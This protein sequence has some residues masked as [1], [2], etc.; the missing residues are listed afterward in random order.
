MRGR[1]PDIFFDFDGGVYSPKF[2][3]GKAVCDKVPTAG[4][5]GVLVFGRRGLPQFL[6]QYVFA[7]CGATFAVDVGSRC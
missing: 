4:I 5:R 1:R 3:N 7:K 2:F 6:W